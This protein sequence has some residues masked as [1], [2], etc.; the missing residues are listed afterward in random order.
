[1]VFGIVRTFLAGLVFAGLFLWR[2]RVMPL[3]VGHWLVDLLGLGLPLL[4]AALA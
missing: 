3:A 1:M 2:R 4:L